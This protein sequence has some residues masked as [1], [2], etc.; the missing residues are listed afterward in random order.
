MSWKKTLNAQRLTFNAQV[1]VQT[2]YTECTENQSE[3]TERSSVASVFLW[4]L[5]DAIST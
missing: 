5:C 2:Y 1:T 4:V 3:F